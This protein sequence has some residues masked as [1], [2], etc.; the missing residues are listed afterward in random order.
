MLKPATNASHHMSQTP[1]SAPPLSNNLLF[2]LLLSIPKQSRNLLVSHYS[3]R[4]TFSTASLENIYRVSHST[5]SS[6][7]HS[8]IEKKKL[9]ILHSF[10]FS[11]FP[12]QSI[13]HTI[14][15]T[16][17]YQST[18][19]KKQAAD[20]ERWTRI[21]THPSSTYNAYTCEIFVRLH[22][23]IYLY[24]IYMHASIPIFERFFSNKAGRSRSRSS[25]GQAT[26]VQSR[27]PPREDKRR[28]W[29][30]G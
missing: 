4:K 23:Y 25:Q 19:K 17:I 2:L 15:T 8:I 1:F 11:L 14:P 16:Y 18:H 12:F 10:P 20:D 27:N 6:H 5:H 30:R 3:Q 24:T 7:F 22:V 21:S 13:R 9:H 26:P 28:R 29:A